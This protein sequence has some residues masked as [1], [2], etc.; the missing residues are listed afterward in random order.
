MSRLEIDSCTGQ[1]RDQSFRV[2]DIDIFLLAIDDDAVAGRCSKRGPFSTFLVGTEGFETPTTD[3]TSTSALMPNDSAQLSTTALIHDM[4][5]TSQHEPGEGEEA[6]STVECIAPQSPPIDDLNPEATPSLDQL[7]C[8]SSSTCRTSLVP[9]DDDNHLMSHYMYFVADTLQPVLHAQ[10]PY[11]GLYAPTAL[12]VATMSDPT[13]DSAGKLSHL[14]LYHALLASAAFHLFN[15]NKAQRQYRLRGAQ[16]RYYANHFL[17]TAINSQSLDVNYQTML[18]AVLSLIT[19]C[20]RD[21]HPT[22][23]I[24]WLMLKHR[25]VISGEDSGDLLA[26]INGATQLRTMRRRWK[27]VSGTTRQLNDIGAF[28]ALLLRTTS[29]TVPASAWDP[30]PDHIG[31]DKSQPSVQSGSCLAYVYGIT[32]RIV[33]AI[34]ETCRLAEHIACYKSDSVE[35][36][37][38]YGLSAACEALGERLLSWTLE[39]E[40]IAAIHPADLLMTKIFYHHASA[41][42]AAALIYYYRR[43]QQYDLDGLIEEIKTVIDHMEAVEDLKAASHSENIARMAPITW[44]MFV[45]SCDA[46]GSMAALCRAWWER[47]QY[48]GIANISTQWH[49]VQQ[50][51]ARKEQTKSCDSGP[52]DWLHVVHDL[53]AHVLPV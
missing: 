51:W 46:S 37:I 17:Q 41:W 27:V 7:L 3:S 43:I 14:A 10:S 28:L 30:E 32:P 6:G 53:R 11:R 31:P 42:H 36:P 20:V 25:Q 33:T 2:K 16:H 47:I 50:V 13:P 5:E 4:C 23:V 18:M 26:H 19:V 49:V 48:Y 12:E 21:N 15:C 39:S 9:N 24:L 38:P 34:H 52:P 1:A 29:F 8:L 40:Q 35:Q 44:P 22:M 45:A